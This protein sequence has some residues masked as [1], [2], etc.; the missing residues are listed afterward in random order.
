MAENPIGDCCH[1][2]VTYILAE[3]PKLDSSELEMIFQRALELQQSRV[4][5]PS[6]QLSQAIEEARAFSDEQCVPLSEAYRLV[7]SWNTK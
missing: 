6:P 3:L 7:K 1:L 4:M 2:S 5:E